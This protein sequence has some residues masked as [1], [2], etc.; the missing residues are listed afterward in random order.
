M[1]ESEERKIE[2]MKIYATLQSRSQSN[3][4]ASSKKVLSIK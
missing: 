3:L 1:I 2:A 4:E